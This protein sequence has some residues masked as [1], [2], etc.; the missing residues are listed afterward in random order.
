M[1]ISNEQNSQLFYMMSDFCLIYLT[2]TVERISEKLS[3]G[4]NKIPRA[5]IHLLHTLTV[6]DQVIII[7][8]AENQ[9][10]INNIKKYVNVGDKLLVSG[11]LQKETY[12]KIERTHNIK[13]V[14][15]Y[16]NVI[17]KADTI[18]IVSSEKHDIEKLMDEYYIGD[19]NG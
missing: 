5:E 18:K 17:V 15:R 10:T 9:Q 16:N 8:Y 2:G 19:D 1:S 12:E 6:Y 3:L 7:V 14:N 11:R 13:F 4:K